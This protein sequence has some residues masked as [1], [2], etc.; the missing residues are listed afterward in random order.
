[1]PLF[2]GDDWLS[3]RVEKAYRSLRP[4]PLRACVKA[5]IRSLFFGKLAFAATPVCTLGVAAVLAWILS[6]LPVPCA[7]QWERVRTFLGTLWQV[8]AS[9]LGITFVV[10][11]L[12]IQAISP[13]LR[14][15]PLFR[16]LIEDSWIVPLG[17]MGVSLA[18]ILGGIVFSVSLYEEIPPYL[19]GLSLSACVLFLLFIG[20]TGYLY[21]RVVR[22]LQPAYIRDLGTRLAERAIDRSIGM[23][24]KKHLN[25]T[26]LRERTSDLRLGLSLA[27]K[28]T[29]MDLTPIRDERRGVVRDINLRHLARLSRMLK[30]LKEPI[31]HG[32]S[33]VWGRLV[34]GLGSPVTEG[35]DVL[36]RVDLEQ[37]PKEVAE[38]IHQSYRIGRRPVWDLRDELAHV[39]DQGLDAIRS[40]RPGDFQHML[41]T[42]RRLF[43]QVLESVEKLRAI[44]HERLDLSQLQIE[45]EPA[46]ALLED[47][48]AIIRVAL[49]DDTREIMN[50]AVYMP[51]ELMRLSRARDRHELFDKSGQCYL[52]IYRDSKTQ[53]IAGV[54]P[55]VRQL[56]SRFLRHVA[57]DS[58]ERTTD[59]N[60]VTRGS[61]YI[62]AVM[63]VFSDLLRAAAEQRDGAAFDQFGRGLDALL[64]TFPPELNLRTSDQ[65]EQFRLQVWFGIGA[66]LIDLMLSSEEQWPLAEMLDY[67][68]RHFP[69]LE[70]LGQTFLQ[71]IQFGKV[72]AFGWL[73]WQLGP[74]EE[75][76]VS[77]VVAE[78]WLKTFYYVQ[79]LH[80]TCADID[81]SGTPLP[82]SRTIV[83]AL[84][85][86]EEKLE[87]L[88]AQG[89]RYADIITPPDSDR[90]RNFI[91][92]HRRAK[93]R[94][95]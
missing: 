48:S 58:L 51:A 56:S 25:N 19:K 92:L 66:G 37:V 13:K 85:L 11:V 53:T 6:H 62:G 76:H 24:L 12:L 68:R 50:K 94:Q 88:T 79:G 7:D 39:K 78:D 31:S 15:D 22:F 34:K 41:D 1:M 91:E 28:H 89:S 9:I 23:E 33:P 75:G 18:A 5:H 59:D 81:D 45:E 49:A 30:E 74:G 46:T 43:E 83:D 21:C 52:F 82:P 64:A 90:I 54:Q 44:D 47:L 95:L 93:E 67:A 71:V 32:D 65:L 36:A 63:R 87:T 77:G 14:S 35:D 27:E 38:A 69:N 60:E 40:R 29:A 57:A 2:R 20:A 55:H 4:Q 42:Y 72:L 8:H 17:L 26:L 3:Y 10:V 86:L 80:L 61:G 70:T 16:A 84:G 73:W